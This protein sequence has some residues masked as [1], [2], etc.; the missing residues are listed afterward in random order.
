MRTIHRA[1]PRGVVLIEA[2]VGGIILAA[3]LAVLI[4]IATQSLTRQKMG[5]EQIVAATLLD[6]LL[7]MVLV[8]GPLEYPK[9]HDMQGRFDPP[10]DAY[11]YRLDFTEQDLS[12]PFLVTATVSWYSG[13]HQRDASV[14]TYIAVRRGDP[15]FEL[16]EPGEMISR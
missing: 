10:F 4:S 6:Q 1:R 7:S 16:R 15:A 11:E 5:E 3:G 12:E 13:G 2:M 9:D 14:R 8:E